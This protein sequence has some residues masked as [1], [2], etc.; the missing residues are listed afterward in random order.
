MTLISFAQNQEDVMLWRALGHIRNGFYIDVGAADPVDLSVT[1]LFYDHGWH[2]INLEP[3]PAYFA[4][5]R[6]A[7]PHDINLQLAAG[8]KA[9]SHTLYSIDDSGLSTLD[10]EIAARHQADG[11]KITKETIEARPLAEICEQH[12]PQGPIHFL[13]IDVEG[14][15]GDVLAG[16][17]LR[18]FRPWIVLLE[19][20]LPNSQEES[21]ADW[22][23]ILTSQGYTFVWFDGLNR[24]YLADEMK[25]ELGR[26]FH[27]QPNVFDAFQAPVHLLQR[28]ERAEQELQH[29]REQA[30]QDSQHVRKQ[31]AQEIQHVRE[32]AAES[33]R[34]ADATS[35]QTAAAIE[36]FAQEA[37]SANHRLAEA[38]QQMEHIAHTLNDTIRKNHAA[39]AEQTQRANEA[40][41]AAHIAHL[42]ARQAGGQVAAMLN[43]TSWRVTA[44]LRMVRRMLPTKQLARQVFHRGV[45]LLMALPGGQ[46]GVR[47]VRAIAPRPVEWL[48][49]RY[50][51]YEEAAVIQ[52]HASAN[53]VASPVASMPDLSAEEVRLYQQLIMTNPAGTT[54]V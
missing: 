23:P 4:S 31:A 8:R 32:Q 27:V 21:Y 9:A 3:Q 25:D 16:A 36:Q 13:K 29:F 45:K 54:P 26:H 15:E 11:W 1:K 28:A 14:A 33:L 47:F 46:R 5:L 10:A 34:D 53:V 42:A 40:L 2:G 39:L 35:R 17:D 43:S 50:R 22:E 38:M 44:P 48:A 18:R 41:H 51:A 20:T 49:R 37:D 52:H 19:A 6:A 7:R 30:T 24:F 12:R